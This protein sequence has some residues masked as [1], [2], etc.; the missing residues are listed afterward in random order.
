M[1]IRDVTKE[2]ALTGEFLGQAKTP[3]GT[4][5]AAFN[6]H[7]KISR[8]DWGLTYNMA[9]E[10]GG[11]LVGEEVNIEI[12]IEFTKMPEAVK[13]AEAGAEPLVAA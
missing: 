2:V 12:D 11:V 1:T 6:A 5:N 3:W 13:P 9:L 4:M 7:T 8:K 10:T